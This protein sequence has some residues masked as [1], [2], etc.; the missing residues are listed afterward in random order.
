[1]LARLTIRRKF[2]SVALIAAILLTLLPFAATAMPMSSSGYYVVRPGDTLSQIAVYH[3]VSIQQLMVANGLLNPNLI[4]V[5][6]RLHIP[7]AGNYVPPSPACYN[8]YTVR[9]GDTMTG[10]AA[11]LGVN[12]WPLAQ[13]NGIANWNAIYTGQRLCIP[14]VYVP[15]AT[16]GYYTV[17]AGDTL[18]SIAARYGV[19]MHYLASLNGIANPNYIYVGQVLRVQ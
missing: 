10:I 4:R 9:R 16:S 15:P 11:W 17:R 3:S 14:N 8:Y 18:S 2:V 13:A 19:G 6:Q 12:A 5:G 1:M 7:A